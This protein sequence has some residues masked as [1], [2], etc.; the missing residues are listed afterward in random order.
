M[1]GDLKFRCLSQTVLLTHAPFLGQSPFQ[2]HVGE[3]VIESKV[4]ITR[5][6][7]EAYA[8]AEAVWGIRVACVRSLPT[9]RAIILAPNRVD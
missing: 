2:E 9:R 5:R 1:T 7:R 4:Q 3:L 6:L 8:F